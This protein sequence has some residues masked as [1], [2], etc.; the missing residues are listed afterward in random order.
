MDSASED[1]QWATKYL[2]DPLTAPEPSEETGPG[3]HF[4]RPQETKGPTVSQSSRH[5]K[6]S[7][8]TSYPTP[9]ASASPTSSSFHPSNPFAPSH[10]QTAFGDYAQAGPS[11]RSSEEPLGNGKGRRRGSSLGERYPGDMSHRPLD[12]L[13]KETKAAHR[14]PHLRKKHIPGTDIIDGLDR[15]GGSYHHEGPYDATLLSRNTSYNS[16]PVAAVAA[17]N[18]EAL[19][20]TPRENIK[21]SLDKHVPLQGTSIIPPGMPGWDGKVMNY[22]EGADLMREPDAAGGP[23][24]R[25]ADVNYLPEDYKGK[26]EPSFSIEKSI[27]DHDKSN[28]HRRFVSEG[29]NAFEMQPRSREPV[30][31]RQRSASGNH[32]D[33]GGPGK[34]A[35]SYVDFESDMRRSHSTGRKVGDGLRKRFGS[36]RLHKKHQDDA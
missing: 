25:W 5:S 30:A 29:G 3:T 7:S 36:L 34:S 4:T 28:S 8:S 35:M 17:S 14:S 26:G 11:R 24:K 21:D 10:R 15:I 16:S 9:P 6:A 12:Q 32:L 20:A 18:A 1:K 13:R 19:R 22:N 23:Y 33:L 31:S 27:K 2:L